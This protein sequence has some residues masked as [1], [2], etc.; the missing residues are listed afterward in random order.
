[1][2]LVCLRDVVVHR[3]LYDFQGRM[4]P[5]AHRASRIV[6]AVYRNPSAVRALGRSM[7]PKAD[8]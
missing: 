5:L 2:I 3:W 6:R 8:R 1:M 4:T 7:R